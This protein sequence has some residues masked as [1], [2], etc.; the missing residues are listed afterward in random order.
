MLY[1]NLML[2]KL[3]TVVF[4]FLS[5]FLLFTFRIGAKENNTSVN[6]SSDLP[7]ENGEYAVLGHPELRLRVF[8]HPT[9]D[10]HPGK[11][12]RPSPTPTPLPVLNCTLSDPKSDAV[13]G[14]TGW[15]L[16][17]EFRYYI[18]PESV[19]A[20]VG[21]QNLA[22]IADNS[23]NVWTSQVNVNAIPAGTTTQ[24]RARY[25]GQNIIAWGRSQSGTLGITYTWY[26]TSTGLVAESDTIMN[27]LYS[28]TWS[29]PQSWDG[30]ICAYDSSYDAQ[31]IMTHEL[32]HW[33]GVDDEYGIEFENNT[34]YGYGD[35]A[36]TKKDTLT[37]GD[38]FSVKNIY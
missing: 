19:P 5:S 31:N 30:L 38:I 4:L 17:S 14:V 27:K 25:D 34:M 11:P 29:D 20:S 6:L 37:N 13:N 36:E 22:A 35:V 2:K 32:G 21:P 18:N 3:I 1:T 7:E 33:F 15:H 28:W 12:E 8:S 26:Y 23:I 9:R 16:P 10:N 24:T